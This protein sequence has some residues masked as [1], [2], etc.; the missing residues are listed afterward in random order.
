MKTSGRLPEICHGTGNF[1]VSG[2]S[3]AGSETIHRRTLTCLSLYFIFRQCQPYFYET[4]F[5]N[6][7]LL[8]ARQI[9]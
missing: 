5:P 1:V 4:P 2:E 6:L 3:G 8:S 9:E 7:N